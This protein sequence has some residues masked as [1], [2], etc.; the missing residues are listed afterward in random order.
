VSKNEPVLTIRAV[1]PTVLSPAVHAVFEEEPTVSSLIVLPGASTRPVGDV[2]EADVPRESAN[3]LIEQL[4]AIGVQREGTIQVLPVATWISEPGFQAEQVA[5]G[6]SADAVVWADVVEKAYDE[7]ELTWTYLSFM[8]MATL[9]AAIAILTDSVILVIGAM[10]LGPEFVA[11]AA[12]GLAMVRKRPMLFKR[13]LRT[14]AVGFAVSISVVTVVTLIGRL[15]GFISIDDLMRPRP[16]TAFIY[17]PNWWSLIVALIAGAAGVLALTSSRSGGL[18]GV[19]ISVTTIPAS[20]NIAVALVFLEWHEVFGSAA[21]LV[22]N[23]IGMAL[24]G[25][26]TLLLQQQV[27]ARTATARAAR[28][29]LR[30]AHQ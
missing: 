1:V 12:L 16:G 19:F 25:W 2:Y 26:A 18:V 29:R 5:P 28:E 27:W 14:L 30:R 21:Q 13:S 22:I 15:I 10:V 6:A 11:I 20:G 17:T 3:A 24:A 4:K 9:L 23:V 7:T 8:I